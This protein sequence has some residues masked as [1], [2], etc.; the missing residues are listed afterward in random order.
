VTEYIIEQTIQNNSDSDIYI[1]NRGVRIGPNAIVFAGTRIE[2]PVY[3]APT[4]RVLKDVHIGMYSYIGW[5]TIVTR[6]KIGRFCSIAQNCQIN[7]FRAH[8]INWLSTHP[9]Q[10]DKGNFAFWPGYE[11]FKKCHF[12]AEESQKEVVIGSDVWIGAN[13]SVFGGTSLG[14]GAIVGAHSLVN[15]DLP[16]YSISYGTPAKPVRDRFT[17]D[18]IDRLLKTKW[19]DAE[20]EKLAELPFDNVEECLQILEE[21]YQ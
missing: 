15:H 3:I 11:K 5:N 2:P 14:H 20:V 21:K 12:N 18:I 17:K 4:A 8:P 13:V 19:W 1:L 9:F 6:S 10:Y 16:A 7:H